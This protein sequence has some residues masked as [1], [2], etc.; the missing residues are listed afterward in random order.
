L[1]LSYKPQHIP[2]AQQ[3]HLLHHHFDTALA[4]HLLLIIVDILF[5]VDCYHLGFAA[6]NSPHNVVPQMPEMTALDW[7]HHKMSNHLFCWATFDGQ[8][9]HI[10]SICDEKVAIVDMPC[11][12]P[13]RGFTIPLK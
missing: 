5:N 7:L 6:T 4:V 12:F 1:S 8:L 13:T 11:M 2:E 9:L 10:H 3:Y